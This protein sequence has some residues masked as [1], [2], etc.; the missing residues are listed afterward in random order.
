MLGNEKNDPMN[1]PH[2]NPHR[3]EPLLNSLPGLLHEEL[4]RVE[5]IGVLYFRLDG[6]LIDANDA[7]LRMCGYSLD[8]LA[9]I[10]FKILT[11]PEFHEEAKRVADELANAGETDPYEK[12]MIRKDG[13]S[14]WGLFQPIRLRGEGWGPDC[15]EFVIDVTARREAEQDLRRSGE[16]Q[17][18][19]LKL[20]DALRP[21]TYAVEV[22]ETASRVLGEYL[23]VDRAYYA[24]IKTVGGAEYFAVERDFYTS[25]MPS[26]VGLHP[27][28]GFGPA[29]V[30]DYRAGRHR[31]VA[32]TDMDVGTEEEKAAWRAIGVRAYIGVPLV[33]GGRLVAAFGVNVS[34]PRAWTPEDVALV[35]EVAERTWAQVERARAET[36]LRETNER[37]QLLMESAT[38]VAIFTTDRVG[39][40]SSWNA[41]SERIFGYREEEA[42]GRNIEV[43]YTESDR[44]ARVHEREMRAAIEEGR[45][46]G[47]RLHVRKD[48]T[49]FFASGLTQP[50]GGADGGFVKIAR[51]MTETLRAEADRR[52]KELARTLVQTQEAERRRIARDL[53]DELGQSMTALRLNLDRL[54]G[55]GRISPDE[56]AEAKRI[57]KKIDDGLE[58]VAWQLRPAALDDLGFVP[59]VEMYVAEWSGLT[60]VQA[61]VSVWTAKDARFGTTVETAFYRIVQEALNNVHKHASARNVEVTIRSRDG[62][63]VLTIDDDGTGFDPEDLATRAHGVGLDGVLERVQIIGGELE[64]ESAPGHGTTIHVRVPR[65]R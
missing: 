11:A 64:I 29:T 42:I 3:D 1:E 59:A 31:A 57:A 54:I 50:L 10:Q 34:E 12:R 49:T 51:D 62:L 26:V 16:R 45:S 39:V 33:K 56:I 19:L 65:G 6:T 8:E 48:G 2:L 58:L 43:L 53:N 9:T 63:L 52:E 35:E 25:G 20:G 4:Q 41:G 24:E 61:R 17:A 28:E 21:L 47:S 38:D 14:W 23:R 13:S 37:L 22:Q 60:G 36:K 55:D 32:D 27:V 7:F 18:F 15:V 30:A 44:G 40:I 5:T 46:V